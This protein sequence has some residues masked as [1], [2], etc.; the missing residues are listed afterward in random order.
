MCI[1]RGSGNTSLMQSRGPLLPSSL[2]DAFPAPRAQ[3]LS[4]G[5][6]RSRMRG[7]DDD[8]ELLDAAATAAGRLRYLSLAAHGCSPRFLG[9]PASLAMLTRLEHLH[10]GCVLLCVA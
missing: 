9:S 4:L 10:L 2:S 3:E 8:G 5:Y 7:H 6:V 1:G